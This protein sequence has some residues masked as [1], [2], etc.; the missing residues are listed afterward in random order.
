MKFSRR[1]V[2]P[3]SLLGLLVSFA[4]VTHA[5]SPAIPPPPPPNL[6]LAPPADDGPVATIGFANSASVR[7]HS[8]KGRFRLTGIKAHETINIQLQ[9]P[10]SLAN[11][12]LAVAA[13]DGGEATLQTPR[14]II[15]A[16]GSASIRFKAPGEPG[17]YRIAVTAGTTRSILQF[18]VVDPKNA[19]WTPPLLKPTK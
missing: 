13:L 7:S 9:F 14:T 8:V 5:Q 2:Q 11:S 15:D 12:S 19:Q 17:L 1:L 16:N 6:L 18:W 3:A 10:S 4:T